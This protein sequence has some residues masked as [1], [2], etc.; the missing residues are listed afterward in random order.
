MNAYEE[1][2]PIQ[3]ALFTSAP[4]VSANAQAEFSGVYLAGQGTGIQPLKSVAAPPRDLLGQLSQTAAAAWSGIQAAGTTLAAGIASAPLLPP[5][6][7]I[8]M[9]REALDMMPGQQ[10]LD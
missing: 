10:K 7:F 2:K 3:N 1:G 5:V 4:G 9:P 8:I 6:P